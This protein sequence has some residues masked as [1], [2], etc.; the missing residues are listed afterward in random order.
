MVAAVVVFRGREG[1][2]GREE[3]GI[4]SMLTLGSQGDDGRARRTRS[5]HVF[6]QWTTFFLFG[7]G[8][9]MLVGSLLFDSGGDIFPPSPANPT[10]DPPKPNRLPDPIGTGSGKSSG[11]ANGGPT[12]LGRVGFDDEAG[13]EPSD[14]ACFDLDDVPPV[15][16]LLPDLPTSTEE[17]LTTSDAFGFPAEGPFPKKSTAAT[18][19]VPS[20]REEG[21]M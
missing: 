14:D 10:P 18:F 13:G 17:T 8:M 6:T 11:N 3:N 19:A 4:N 12:R 15:P 21:G 2:E 7:G 20:S 5:T 9:N 16:L 1:T